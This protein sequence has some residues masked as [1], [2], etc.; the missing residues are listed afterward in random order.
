MALSNLV[1]ITADKISR[2]ESYQ[3]I[4]YFTGVMPAL[5]SI[6]ISPLILKIR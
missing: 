3:L 6:S 2:E 1:G 5:F 4:S